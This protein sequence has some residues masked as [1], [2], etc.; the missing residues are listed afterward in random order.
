MPS[1]GAAPSPQG[2]QLSPLLGAGG[3]R[4]QDSADLVDQWGFV[5]G[6]DDTLQL[7]LGLTGARDWG[8]A[9]CL[10]VKLICTPE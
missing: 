4:T 6:A 7:S 3:E 2:A 8:T 5:P 10:G 9:A 1:A